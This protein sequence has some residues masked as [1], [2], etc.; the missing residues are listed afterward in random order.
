MNIVI[1]GYRGTGKSTVSRLLAR[2][3]D[4]KLVNL[5]ELIVQL[6]GMPIPRIVSELGWPRFREMEAKIVEEVTAR[7]KDVV[8]DCGGGVVLDDN[9]TLLLR[10]N[11]K[12]IL[13]TASFEAILKRIRRDPNRP[14]LKEGLSFEAEQ[15]QILAERQE[16]YLAVADMTFD[17]TNDD[18][19]KTVKEIV[20]HLRREAWI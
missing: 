16:K 17:T 13:L 10:K 11:G 15:S 19:M 20:G 5:D 14:P 8:I 12:T 18:P 3:L 1:L 9:N 7:E 4:R 6:A 2:K